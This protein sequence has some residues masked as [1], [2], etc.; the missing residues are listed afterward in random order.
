MDFTNA[1]I[2]DAAAKVD[3]D[4]MTPSAAAQAWLEENSDLV[5]QWSDTEACQS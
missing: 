5:K 2:A 3:V 4:E 1:M